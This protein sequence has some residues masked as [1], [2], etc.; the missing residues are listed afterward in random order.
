[1]SALLPL[2]L[3]RVPVR[4]RYQLRGVTCVR[5]LPARIG[6]LLPIGHTPERLRGKVG[7]SIPP[8]YTQASSTMWLPRHETRPNRVEALVTVAA[9]WYRCNS[10]HGVSIQR[11]T[12]PARQCN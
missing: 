8:E 7:C 5:T 4:V 9:S 6:D 11:S 2:P 3:V 10:V 1:M 12:I